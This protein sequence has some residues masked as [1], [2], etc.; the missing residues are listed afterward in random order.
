M[1]HS[2]KREDYS[3]LVCLKCSGAVPSARYAHLRM[4]EPRGAICVPTQSFSPK[5]SR[6]RFLTQS[7]SPK[8]SRRRFLAESFSPKV[9]RRRFLTEGFSPKVSRR[10]FSPKVSHLKF[11]I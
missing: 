7:F 1:L 4:T 10:R 3:S 9:S 5:V 6:R 11:L 2:S 8:V